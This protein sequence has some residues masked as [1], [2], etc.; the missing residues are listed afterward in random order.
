MCAVLI[1]LQ[2]SSSIGT[3]CDVEV[4]ED[5]SESECDPQTFESAPQTACEINDSPILT[6]VLF[7]LLGKLCLEYQMVP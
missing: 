7:C 3:D 2:A 4:W 1:I 6:I 5:E